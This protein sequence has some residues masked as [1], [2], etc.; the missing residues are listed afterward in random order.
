MRERQN[1]TVDDLFKI[2]KA[3]KNTLFKFTNE[4]IIGRKYNSGIIKDKDKFIIFTSYPNLNEI[5]NKLNN[6]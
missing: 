3:Y 6:K 5:K 2:L 4:I 1:F